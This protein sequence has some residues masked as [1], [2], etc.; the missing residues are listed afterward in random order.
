MTRGNETDAGDMKRRAKK[1][2][3]GCRLESVLLQSFYRSFARSSP[4]DEGTAA[5]ERAPFV[6]YRLSQRFRTVVVQVMTIIS[7]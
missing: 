5:R 2:G 6:C 3:K 1:M 7:A 4:S